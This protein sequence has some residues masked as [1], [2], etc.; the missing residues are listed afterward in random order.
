MPRYANEVAS[1]PI[2][3]SSHTLHS[4]PLSLGIYTSPVLQSM[5]CYKLFIN[6]KQLVFPNAFEFIHTVFFK[7][8]ECSECHDEKV[9]TH[10]FSF[11]KTLRFTCK[12][13][14]K[15]FSRDFQMF[16][17][18]DKLCDFC[19]IPWCLPCITPESRVFE[20]S[21]EALNGCLDVL[22]DPSQ[23]YFNKL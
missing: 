13:C 11:K 23:D 6:Q 10:T 7:R 14:R 2:A 9:D 16:S 3:L 18:R 19:S 22:I 12:N 21:I 15:T 5:V 20:E 17:A 1:L 8:F 4:S